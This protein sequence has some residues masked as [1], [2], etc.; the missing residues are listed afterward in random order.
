MDNIN[1]GCRKEGET[2]LA[3]HGIHPDWDFISTTSL[4]E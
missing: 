3:E 1:P 2:F 4:L